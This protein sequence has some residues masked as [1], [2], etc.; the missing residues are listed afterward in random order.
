MDRINSEG[1][2]EVDGKRMFNTVLLASNQKGFLS[3]NLSDYRHLLVDAKFCKKLPPA[4]PSVIEQVQNE[5]NAVIQETRQQISQAHPGKS[6][7]NFQW[8]L[9]IA[10][11]PGSDWGLDG[12][13]KVASEQQ[14]AKGF[15]A[16][17]EQNLTLLSSKLSDIEILSQAKKPSGRNLSRILNSQTITQLQLDLWCFLRLS[18]YNFLQYR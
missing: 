18:P 10:D 7:Q 2:I 11:R 15:L 12:A 16:R 17:A 13:A 5:L 4:L 8:M 1:T 14:K 6:P 3:L 9:L